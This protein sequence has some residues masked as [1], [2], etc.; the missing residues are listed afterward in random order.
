MLIFLPSSE[1]EIIEIDAPKEVT[2]RSQRGEQI[3]F[4]IFFADIHVLQIITKFPRLSMK[5]L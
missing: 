1:I 5:C 2:K 4:M 3:N